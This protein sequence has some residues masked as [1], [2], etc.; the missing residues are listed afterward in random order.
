MPSWAIYGNERRRGMHAESEVSVTWNPADKNAGITLSA[1]DL[2]ATG[3]SG[4][5]SVRATHAATTNQKVYYEAIVDVRTAN[6]RIGFANLSNPLDN[7]L[8]SD[9][10]GTAFGIGANTGAC[11]VEGVA[12]NIT[13][14]TA[15]SNGQRVGLA[16]DSAALLF[17]VT[18]NGTDWNTALGGT[19]NPVTGEGGHDVG[20]AFDIV[21]PYPIFQCSAN[22]DK[23]TA[24]F[25]AADFGFTMP[26]GFSVVPT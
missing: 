23:V 2:T 21:Y 17:W 11:E 10:A 3:G 19:Q 12:T 18:L 1:G 14:T 6:P 24:V 15:W 4:P 16:Y 5:I 7:N 9:F 25:A 13:S 26:S 22:A 8:G 20:G